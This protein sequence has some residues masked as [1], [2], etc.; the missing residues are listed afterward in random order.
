MPS[1]SKAR[2]EADGLPVTFLESPADALPLE[3]S[4]FDKCIISLGL[5]HMS[6]QLRQRT[7]AEACRL[8]VNNG[9]LYT[10]EYHLPANIFWRPLALLLA[11]LDSSRESL[12]MMRSGSLPAEVRQARFEIK[13]QEAICHGIIG[14]LEA[15]KA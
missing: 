12:K 13:R 10:V 11:W 4:R 2:S 7:L 9:R 6:P 8:L 1:I 3:D 14:L 15:E 5:H